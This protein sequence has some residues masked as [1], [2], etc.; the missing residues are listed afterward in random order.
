MASKKKDIQLQ[1]LINNETLWDEMLQ[2]KGLTVIDVYQAWCGPCKAIQALFRKL[3]NELSSEEELLHFAVAEAD[4]LASLQPFRDKCEPV[5]LFSLNGKIVS[6]VRGVNAPLVN[7]K[8]IQLI[9]EERKILA[10]EMIR[11]V[12][13]ELALIDSD[14]GE[15]ALETSQVPLEDI[16]NVLIIRP[17][18]VDEERVEEIKQLILNFGVLIVD[19]EQRIL[20]DEQVR[21]FYHEISY[22]YDFEDFV[23]YTTSTPSYLLGISLGPPGKE[24]EGAE[25]NRE[26]KKEEKPEEKASEP[27]EKDV[28][29]EENEEQNAGQPEENAGQPEENEEQNEEQ[30]AGQP[31]EKEEQPDEKEEQLDE[32]EPSIKEESKEEE[33]KPASIRELLAKKELLGVCDLVDDPQKARRHLILFFPDFAKSKN[34]E[35][36]TE[37]TLA[38][39]RPDKLQ[40]NPEDVQHILQMIE[41]VIRMQKELTLSEEEAK[42]LY[43]QF[44]YRE[45]FSALIEHVTSAPVVAFCLERQNAVHFWRYILGP[46]ASDELPIS[47]REIL[48]PDNSQYNQLHGKDTPEEATKEIRICF[49]YEHT[50]VLIKPHAFQDLRGGII[51]K[52]QEYGFSLSHMKEIQ[53][54]VD[55]VVKLY[56]AHQGQDF[57]EDLVHHMTEGPCMAMI[58]SKENAVLDWRKFAGPVD[59]EYARKEEP[60]TIR[61]LFGKDILDN[62]VHASSSKEQAMMSIE[63]IFGDIDMFFEET[64]I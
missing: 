59:P 7:A 16:Y 2:N 51:R 37:R 63:L 10:G 24:G 25:E 54:S 22:K 48:G 27:E 15:D 19:E 53:L 58:I 36:L 9:E 14:E 13:P 32:K 20:D 23:L 46:S 26:E 41:F 64:E 18:A 62:A 31:E 11:P 3:R 39:F 6:M 61:A 35:L 44:K 1:T 55:K 45:Y 42:T 4:S 5:F 29:P 8:V 43:D 30:N 52:I 12:L 47:L 38:I 17:S 49:P 33:E 21:D 34:L 40:G 57:F 56:K 28:P 60:D 50:M